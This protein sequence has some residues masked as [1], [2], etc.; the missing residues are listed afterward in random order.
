MSAVTT[1]AD[2]VKY[3]LAVQHIVAR[4]FGLIFSNV[5]NQLFC[6]LYRFI[7]L[8]TN[9]VMVVLPERAIK[10]IVFMAFCKF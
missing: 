10:L 4:I 3:Q 2:S 5:I 1:I 6:E 9:Q 8:H 7:T